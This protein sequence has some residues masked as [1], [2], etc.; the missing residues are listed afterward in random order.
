MPS[1]HLVYSPAAESEIKRLSKKHRKLEKDLEKWVR[2]LKTSDRWIGKVVPGYHPP[3]WKVRVGLP[4]ARLSASDALRVVY[5]P[6]PGREDVLLV[7]V[8]YKPEKADFTREEL[9]RSLVQVRP[10]IQEQLEK[11]GITKEQ[12]DKLFTP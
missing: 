5:R 3:T 9:L 12:I 6:V 4:S 1:F 7:L 8:Y 11:A 2:K 10:K